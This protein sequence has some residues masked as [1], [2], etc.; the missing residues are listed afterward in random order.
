MTGQMNRVLNASIKS[1]E[2]SLARGMA[3]HTLKWDEVLR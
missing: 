2:L 1:G 3:H